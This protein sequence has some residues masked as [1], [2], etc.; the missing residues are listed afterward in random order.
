MLIDL[1]AHYPM[2]L[3][4]QNEGTAHQALAPL[5]RRFVASALRELPL[6]PF[7]LRR[8]RG[9]P[10]VTIELMRVGDVGVLLSVLHNPLDEMDVSKSYG[11]PPD[12][13][14]LPS[15]LGQLKLVEDSVA[16]D[17][18]VA[19]AHSR[20]ELT[21]AFAAN[22]K[23]LIH[24]VEGGYHLG[25]TET[26]IRKAVGQLATR[27]VAYITLAHLFWRDIATNAPALPFLPDSLYR[28]IFRQPPK[29]LSELGVIA[30][31]A[32]LDHQILIDITHMSSRA[33]AATLELMDRRDPNKEIPV[34][35]TH[36][37][38]RFRRL[39]RRE[40]NLSDDTIRRI[41]ERRGLI[42]IILCPHYILGGGPFR[43]RQT[44]NFEASVD[45]LC[46]H[47]DHIHDVTESLDYV[48]IGS[49]SRWLDQASAD[50]A[51]PPRAHGATTGQ[52]A[53]TLRSRRRRED[54]LRQR[55]SRSHQPLRLEIGVW[56][57]TRARI[58]QVPTL[59]VKN[60]RDGFGARGMTGQLVPGTTSR[61]LSPSRSPPRSFRSPQR[62]IHLIGFAHDGRALEHWA[63]RDDLGGDDA[64]SVSWAGPRPEGSTIES[65]ALHAKRNSRFGRKEA[66]LLCMESSTASEI[67]RGRW[68]RRT[69]QCCAVAFDAWN[70]GDLDNL[71]ELHLGED[72][73]FAIGRIRPR[74]TA[75]HGAR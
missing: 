44:A 56:P 51:R 37:A 4:P 1:H 73:I 71:R 8:A 18:G 20:R 59:H 6:A 67:L 68:P 48:G 75:A 61:S 23:V 33:T 50:R 19:V 2:H 54:L 34:L 40:Y 47:I 58:D 53:E 14:Y 10:G 41:A 38:C 72:R 43:K 60:P 30:A 39:R 35:A 11:A 57:P 52:V 42:G 25:G 29:G 31:E 13:T 36:E 15:L 32:M 5:A 49:R 66:V 3:V 17:P 46:T 45:A 65:A 9:K 7:Q 16:S 74:G 27:G 69:S 24:C 26:E 22:Q 62:H 63:V 21:T 28:L 12:G 70:S 64:R 55:R